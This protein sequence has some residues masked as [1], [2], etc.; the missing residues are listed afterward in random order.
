MGIAK[1]IYHERFEKGLFPKPFWTPSPAEWSLLEKMFACGRL[2]YSDLLFA[3]DILSPCR[4]EDEFLAA[5]F[6]HLMVSSREGHLCVGVEGSSINPDPSLSWL[7]PYFDVRYDTAVQPTVEE[8]KTLQRKV[9]EGFLNMAKRFLW[10]PSLDT[11][12]VS[13]PILYFSKRF[14]LQR[15]WTY[16]SELLKHLGRLLVDQ[17]DHLLNKDKMK[18][19]L[20]SLQREKLLLF[21]QAQAIEKACSNNFTIISGGPGTGK[22][23]TVGYFVK[24]FLRSSFLEEHQ[25]ME[26][27]LVAP[28]GKAV[29]NLQQSFS[30]ALG[31]LPHYVR[32]YCKTL[33]AL[34]GIS[35]KSIASRYTENSPLD[36]DIV[37]V[38]ESSMVDVY[39]MSQLFAAIKP[40]SRL[41]LL[42]DKDQLPSVE[43]GSVFADLSKLVDENE[44]LKSR[45]VSLKMCMRTDLKEIIRFSGWVHEG[46]VD[47]VLACLN[48]DS[49]NPSVQRFCL[50]F[51]SSSAQEEMLTHVA[52]KYPK[53]SGKEVEDIF[54]KFQKFRILSPLR[55]GPFGVD[56]VNRR[57]LEHFFSLSNE[58][59]WLALPIIVA[60]SHHKLEIFNGE[61]GVLFHKRKK[62]SSFSSLGEEDYA[63]FPASDRNHPYFDSLIGFRKIPAILLPLYEAA[64]C[65]S[66]H[67]SQGSEFESVFLVLPKGSEVFGREVIYT[68]ATRARKSLEVAAETPTIKGVLEQH[69]YRASGIVER[70]KGYGKGFN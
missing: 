44:T 56:A 66:V 18:E 54:L 55:K 20:L 19:E 17:V 62:G 7:S 34:L 69:S 57:L 9:R 39:L 64:Y 58:G 59:E 45:F 67:K 4:Q 48:G 3:K 31:D 12:K 22:T 13:V 35:K 43:A 50:D 68:A 32:V 42:G 40:G 30:K 53:S 6:C 36:A 70:F 11:C 16:E 21:E 1:S 26:I 8:I 28:T 2:L 25:R 63:I 10:K 29:S 60:R 61:T 5:A 52:S 24:V 46:R 27:A 38:D 33:H 47:K 37:V 23:Y 65:L 14:Y 49:V 41:I 15:F 51:Q